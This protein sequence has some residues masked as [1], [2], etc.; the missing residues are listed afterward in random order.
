MIDSNNINTNSTA[1]WESLINSIP[2]IKTEPE[3]EPYVEITEYHGQN[4][5]LIHEKLAK[6]IINITLDQVI[7]ILTTW[8][9]YQVLIKISCDAELKPLRKDVL[10]ITELMK[11]VSENI[12]SNNLHLFLQ[13]TDLSFL[14]SIADWER[15]KTELTKQNGYPFNEKALIKKAYFELLFIAESLGLKPPNQN[16]KK[17]DLKSFLEIITGPFQNI[18]IK[19][20]S[21]VT[22]LEEPNTNSTDKLVKL[23]G[24]KSAYSLFKNNLYYLENKK[25][26]LQIISIKLPEISLKE[27]QQLF[28]DNYDQLKDASREDLAKITSLTGHSL[29]TG[30]TLEY[31]Y[32]EYSK[33]KRNSDIGFKIDTLVQQCLKYSSNF[34]MGEELL[35]I[36]QDKIAPLIS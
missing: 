7:L 26:E 23:L 11:L 10:K 6:L 17:N 5:A 21:L 13:K 22:L 2:K 25:D 1:M 24:N 18:T 8:H 35:T 14:R 36:Y 16:Y 32:Q 28:P 12:F 33:A 31:Y 27:L 20:C 9:F 30:R 19:K 34:D 29:L 15:L 4:L 3:F